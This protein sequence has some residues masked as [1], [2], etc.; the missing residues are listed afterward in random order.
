MSERGLERTLG[1]LQRLAGAKGRDALVEAVERMQEA[2]RSAADPQAV[3]RV[4]A[5]VDRWLA[6][7]LGTVLRRAE[8]L[9]EDERGGDVEVRTRGPVRFTSWVLLAA[10]GG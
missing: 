4:V 3:E 8:A 7:L 5:A 1:A 6:Q 9:L 2:L 10:E